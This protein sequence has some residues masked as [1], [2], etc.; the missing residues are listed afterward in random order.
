SRSQQPGCNQCIDICST[1]AIRA[2]GDHIFVEQHLCMGCGACTTVCP[3]GALTYGYPGA[4]DL[5]ARVRILLATYRAAGGRDACLL[6]HDERGRELIN[7][8]GRRGKGLP[9]RV[10]PVELHHMAAAGIDVWLGA[11]AYGATEVC[12]LATG[13]EAPEY[14]AA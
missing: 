8:A 4:P 7:Q 3:S 14:A 1:R 12:V 5:G 11:L 13:A 2:D 10:I 9:A 6:F